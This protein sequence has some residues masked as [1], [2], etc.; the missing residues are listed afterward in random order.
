MEE[1]A[2]D[3]LGE[4][5]DSMDFLPDLDSM[6]GAFRPASADGES[7]TT[8]YS[9]STPSRK[10]SSGGKGAEWSGDFNAKDMAKGLQTVLKKDKEG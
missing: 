4:I 9:V 5:S 8:E 3:M 2:G 1:P 10:P 7:D 6:A